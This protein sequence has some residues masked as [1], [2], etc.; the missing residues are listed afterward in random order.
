[1]KE[2]AKAIF[3]LLP[4]LLS[5][6]IFFCLVGLLI[7]FSICSIC[8]AMTFDWEGWKMKDQQPLLLCTVLFS[9]A[10]A[11]FFLCGLRKLVVAVAVCSWF[12]ETDGEGDLIKRRG[13]CCGPLCALY[14]ALRYHS[15]TIAFGSFV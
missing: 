10:W 13:C 15:G 4:I 3:S 6:F 11:Y 7:F 1:M 8:G 14:G 9:Y 5:P 12:F 2:S